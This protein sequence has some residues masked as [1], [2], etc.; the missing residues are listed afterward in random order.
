M[1][2]RHLQSVFTSQ[3]VLG[4]NNKYRTIYSLAF[5][6]ILNLFASGTYLYQPRIVSWKWNFRL[7]L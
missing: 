7:N 5:L 4:I 6:R 2:K 1:I 3:T